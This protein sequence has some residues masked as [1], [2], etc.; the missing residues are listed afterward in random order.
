[1]ITIRRLN[2]FDFPKLKK[3]VSYLCSDDNDYL[4]KNLS[5]V[6]MG[7]VNAMMPLK[8]KFRSESFILIEDNEILGLITVCTTSGNPYKINIT[9]LIFKENRYEIGKRL[10][11]F[12]LQKFGSKGANSFMV[13]VDECHDELFDLFINGCSFR[14]CSCETLWKKN[15]TNFVKF[16]LGLI[17][18]Q[19]SDAK[20]IAQLY[21]DEIIN[22]YKPSL[23][24]CEQEF[25]QPF[26]QGF[27]NSYKNRYIYEENKN[28]IGYFSITTDDNTNF[29]LDMTLN[30]GYD[31]DYD[32]IIN[33]LLNEISYKKQTF[34]PI[35]K[36]KKYFKNSDKL[37]EYLRTH[38]YKPIQTQHILTKDFYKEV[39]EDS[40]NWKVFLLGEEHINT[41]LLN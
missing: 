13:I 27:R 22:I 15:S 16:N 19:N 30:S 41:G 20:K 21:N 33:S 18:A 12:V 25:Q 1:M 3:L 29:I 6:P 4:V 5:E 38:D 7:L 37:E 9:R 2:C 36:Q 31:F 24:R 23:S 26:F 14:Q 8:F 35:I 10:I 28:I 32:E 40:I 11:D 39:K 17:N 34:Y